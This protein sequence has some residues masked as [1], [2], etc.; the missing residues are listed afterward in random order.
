M[1]NSL[2]FLLT[3][4]FLGTSTVSYAAFVMPAKNN[5]T[6]VVKK[7]LS[8]ANEAEMKAS[9]LAIP[10]IDDHQMHRNTKTGW[11]GIVSVC[12]AVLSLATLSVG[13]WVLFGIA[14][15]VFGLLGVSHRKHYNTG[16]A[17][18]GIVVGGLEILLVI[19]ILL[20][21]AALAGTVL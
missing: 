14:A 18:V 8:I 15:F 17:I 5:I 9:T 6:Q 1:K 13:F 4:L 12:C 10:V 16:L 2:I 21:I 19:V 7:E 11:Q 3:V 20:L